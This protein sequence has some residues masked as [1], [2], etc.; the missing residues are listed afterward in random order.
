VQEKFS[1]SIRCYE[2]IEPTW[3]AT[4]AIALKKVSVHDG[5]VYQRGG[6]LAML[7]RPS[8]TMVRRKNQFTPWH[9][10]YI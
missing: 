4:K 1:P 5:V 2:Q 3:A 8:R 7:Q 10:L 9:L 6:A